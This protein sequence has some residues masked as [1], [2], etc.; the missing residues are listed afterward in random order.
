MSGSATPE[1]TLLI[2]TVCTVDDNAVGAASKHSPPCAASVS[3]SFR[4]AAE[5][6][7]VD[8]ARWL[9][10]WH[11]PGTRAARLVARCGHA[12]EDILKP[13]SAS[14]LVRARDHEVERVN[15]LFFTIEMEPGAVKGAHAGGRRAARAW[16]PVRLRWI[17]LTILAVVCAVGAAWGGWLLAGGDPSAIELPSWASPGISSVHAEADKEDRLQVI[18]QPAGASVILDG[19]RRG[20]T[21]LV[22]TVSR[23][24]HALLLRHPDAIDEQRQISVVTDTSMNVSMWLRRPTATLLKPAY[25]G[26]TISEVR[27]LEDG[28]LALSM[29]VIATSRNRS[30]SASR[31]AWIYDPVRGSLTPFATQGSTAPQAAEIAISPDGHRLAYLQADPAGVSPRPTEVWVA[32]A[33]DTTAPAVCVFALPSANTSATSGSTGSADVEEIHDVAWTPDGSHLLITVRL[34]AI[35]GGYVPAPRSRL[36]LV[37]AS[38]GQNAPPVEVMTLPAEVVTGSYTWAADGNWVAFLTLAPDVSGGNTFVA[39]CAVDTR[40]GG[41]ISAFRY[42]ADLGRVADPVGPLPVAPVAW[43]P[44]GE[45]RLVYAAATPKITVSNPLGLP[46]TSGG[47]P[48]LFTASPGGQGLSAEEGQRLGAVSGLL[49]PAWTSADEFDGATL[50]ALARSDKGNRPLVLRGIDAVTGVPQNLDI[51]LPAGIGGSG[52]VAARWD[53]A[54]GRLLVLARHDNSRSGLLDFWLVQLHAQSGRV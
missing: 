5:T 24:T 39:L 20:S 1:V 29:A 33:A 9:G 37:D 46:T 18:S 26:A 50:I 45:G 30:E 21:P 35:S 25:P 34:A 31:E 41:A 52:A 7:T 23:G 3:R 2:Q 43:S 28:R 36:L 17:G 12:R 19:N 48:G 38:P 6:G 47:D 44:G 51:S 42:I 32:S 22:L 27:F 54:H 10:R 15:F 14:H 13:T 11:D 8:T 4:S 40:A 16:G 53:L 49:A